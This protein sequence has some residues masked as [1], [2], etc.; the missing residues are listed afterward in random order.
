MKYFSDGETT[1]EY[2]EA[3]A[4]VALPLPQHHQKNHL[5]N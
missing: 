4:D 5:L 3:V 2:S 1:K